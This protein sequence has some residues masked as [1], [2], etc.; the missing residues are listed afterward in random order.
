M[1]C[2]RNCARSR[3]A[4]R[5]GI[6]PTTSAPTWA[7]CAQSIN[8]AYRPLG[9]AG[10][11]GPA[12]RVRGA[13]FADGRAG[14]RRFDAPHG[15]AA[16]TVLKTSC[17]RSTRPACRKSS[18]RSPTGSTTSSA[19]S[20]AW[21]KS[22]AVR[23]LEDKL[24]SIATAMEQFGSMIQPHD[25]AMSEQFAAV[26]TP[27]RRDQPGDRRQRPHRRHRRSGP[28]AAAG[29]PPF[30]ALGEQIELMGQAS[31]SQPRRP[32]TTWRTGWKR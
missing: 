17:M 29:R 28:D 20:A 15:T 11:H 8:A 4:R 25:R 22:P 10:G 13:A 18:W 5:T 7:A 2:A 21:A 16:G 30:N 19:I 24:I 14:A 6:S 23:A 1:R 9:R 27:A 26:D 31:V 3:Q 12:R 32:P